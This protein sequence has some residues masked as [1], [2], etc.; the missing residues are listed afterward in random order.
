MK[1]MDVTM[2]FLNNII[3]C[4]IK[5]VPLLI[6]CV[7][8]MNTDKNDLNYLSTGGGWLYLI[9]RLTPKKY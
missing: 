3:E 5:Y 8:I 7:R 1:L 2:K 4:V 6:L 9:L